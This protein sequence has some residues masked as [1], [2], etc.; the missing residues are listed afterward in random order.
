M[1]GNDKTGT[2]YEF[3]RNGELFLI[4]NYNSGKV[5]GIAQE[6]FKGYL[7]GEYLFDDGLMDGVAKAYYP[8][9]RVISNVESFEKGKSRGIN[10]Y[11]DSVGIVKEISVN[12]SVFYNSHN[13]TE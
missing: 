6:Y 9:G 5:S 10:L 1:K 4:L 7:I 3:K 12:D 11:F 2:W 13:I 8:S